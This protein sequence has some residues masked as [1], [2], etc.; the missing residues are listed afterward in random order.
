M[1]LLVKGQHYSKMYLSLIGIRNESLIL[2]KCLQVAHKS[3]ITRESNYP[4]IKCSRKILCI[5][6]TP[7][8]IKWESFPS[9]SGAGY[10]EGIEKSS[11]A[12]LMLSILNM[13][14]AGKEL[15][16]QFTLMLLRK[17][18]LPTAVSGLETDGTPKLPIKC[19][20]D[21]LFIMD[22]MVK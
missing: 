10:S 22:R 2:L 8:Y 3:N 15:N 6:S 14:E 12:N 19:K 17:Q 5:L 16:Q 13:G 11:G 4:L 18:Y 7:K 21:F 20:V 9:R 1:V